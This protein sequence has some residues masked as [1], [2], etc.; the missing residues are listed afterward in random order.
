MV[1]SYPNIKA[2]SIL[3]QL[4]ATGSIELETRDSSPTHSRISE[5]LAAFHW[6][7][8]EATEY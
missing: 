5:S 7:F 3:A 1:D 2:S 8:S 6:E 4:T